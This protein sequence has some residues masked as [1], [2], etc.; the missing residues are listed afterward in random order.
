[1]L[2]F[3][4]CA[5]RWIPFL[6]QLSFSS[7]S[8]SPGFR[9]GAGLARRVLRCPVI[10]RTGESIPFLFILPSSF[11]LSVLAPLSFP[12]LRL[13]SKPGYIPPH[14]GPLLDCKALFQQ[15]LFFF[16]PSIFFFTLTSPF[17]PSLEHL[18]SY[19]CESN[20]FLSYFNYEENG[21]VT[22]PFSPR[23]GPGFDGPPPLDS[24]SFFDDTGTSFS[25]Y[26][27]ISPFETT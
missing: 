25:W 9:H 13:P 17:L 16:L 8:C 21:F 26:F 3:S 18:A 15:P 4:P 2:T 20:S 7:S 22:Y 6:H 12:Y 10:S 11:P 24:P 27:L 5:P 1:M 23:L 19:A 14:A